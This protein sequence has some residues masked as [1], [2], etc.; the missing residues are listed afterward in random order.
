MKMELRS[1]MSSLKRCKAESSAGCDDE[2]SSEKKKKHRVGGEVNEMSS[3]SGSSELSF[4][5]SEVESKKRGDRIRLPPLVKTSRRRVSVLPSRFKDSVFVSVK[6]EEMGVNGTVGGIKVKNEKF[7]CNAAELVSCGVRRRQKMGKVRYE[8][9]SSGAFLHENL[10]D[11]EVVETESLK[12]SDWIESSS[13]GIMKKSAE[14]GSLLNENVVK[15]ELMGLSSKENME[16]R[17]AFYRPEDF[18][19]GD[20]VWAKSGKRYPAWPAIVI[21]PRL[22]APD[23]VLDSCVAGALCVMFFGYS[24]DGKERDYAWVKH[25]MIFPFLEYVDRFQGQT[26]LYRSKPSDFRMAIEEAFL[27]EHGFMSPLVEKQN[28]SYH[29]SIP[30]VIYEATGSNQDQECQSQNQAS[31]FKMQSSSNPSL[32]IAQSKGAPHCD[33]CGSTLASKTTKKTKGSTHKGQLLCKH[34][35]KLLKSKQYCGICKKIWHHSDGGNWVRCDGCKVWVHAECG[36]ISSKLFKD[37]E[38]VDYYCPDCK[39]KCNF[40]LSDSECLQP[41]KISDQVNGKFSPP[42]KI[43]V[44]CKGMEA[45]YFPRLHLVVC[46]CGSCGSHKRSLSEWERHTGSKTKNWKL[47]VKVKGS[48]LQLEQWVCLIM[49]YIYLDN[50]YFDRDLLLES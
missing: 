10:I 37:L 20:I 40:E 14:V 36:K 8:M 22:Q 41:R 49:H 44:I 50:N 29:Q 38:E 39:A 13:K 3:V 18:G 47:S 31:Y 15:C 2:E 4:C 25:G 11:V 19:L 35:A 26:Q 30:R 24:G 46:Q 23:T 9:S 42:D 45:T 34:C 17:K 28:S 48:M 43:T 6:V 7:S 21:D 1:Q 16:K 5:P 27:A 32:D 12:I 33:G